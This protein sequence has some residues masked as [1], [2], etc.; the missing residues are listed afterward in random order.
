M[1][2]GIVNIRIE[3]LSQIKRDLEL[4]KNAV[5]PESELT[6]W[7]KNELAEARNTPDDKYIIMDDIEKEFSQ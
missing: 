7:A 1:D 6:E 5:M 2:A 4:I 3:N